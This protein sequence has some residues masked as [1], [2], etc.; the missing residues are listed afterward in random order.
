MKNL[1]K[2]SLLAL[3]FSVVGSTRVHAGSP[4]G[5]CPRDQVQGENNCAPEVDP[6][7]AIAGFTLLAGAVTVL[8][9]R[10]SK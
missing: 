2:Y 3:V 4:D 10:R 6:S 9:A 1:L 7:M 5:S 8:R